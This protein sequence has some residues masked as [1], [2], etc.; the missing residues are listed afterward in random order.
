MCHP[1]QRALAKRCSI[2]KDTVTSTVKWLEE[3]RIIKVYPKPRAV[4]VYEVLRKIHWVAVRSGRTV[5]KGK[6]SGSTAQFP[7][8]SGRTVEFGVFRVNCPVPSDVNKDS[9]QGASGSASHLEVLEPPA[10]D[11]KLA[12]L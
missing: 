12:F 8:R 6:L 1:G 2:N 9:T 3:H 5:K 7:V 11:S 10:A 4:N